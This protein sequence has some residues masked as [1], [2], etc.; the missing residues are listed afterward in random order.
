[1][2]P[3]IAQE[4]APIPG[5]FPLEVQIKITYSNRIYSRFYYKDPRAEDKKFTVLLY[6]LKSNKMSEDVEQRILR[7][8]EACLESGAMFFTITGADALA[9]PDLVE[10]LVKN[11]NALGGYAT[12]NTNAMSADDRIAARQALAHMDSA[13]ASIHNPDEAA[14]QNLK[15][16]IDVHLSDSD[17]SANYRFKDEICFRCEQG[18]YFTVINPKIQ[19]YTVLRNDEMYKMASGLY[20]FAENPDI[21]R[22]LKAMDALGIVF[23]NRAIMVSPHT[24]CAPKYKILTELIGQDFNTP[25]SVYCLRTDT[26]GRF[27]CLPNTDEENQAYALAAEVYR[28]QNRSSM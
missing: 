8:V 17:I 1:M 25:G 20:N 13:L 6:E 12:V 10:R 21:L 16:R 28:K 3:I 23:S 18:D 22:L 27:F 5:W 15:H 24:K 4:F 11:I 14:I 26:A 19:G 2:Q 9:Y 7:K